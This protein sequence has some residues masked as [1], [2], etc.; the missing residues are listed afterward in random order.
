VPDPMWAEVGI[1]V[2][3]LRPGAVLDE[4]ELLAWLAPKVARYKLPRRVF[5]WDE[6]PRSG[7][8]KITKKLIRAELDA[9][10]CLPSENSSASAA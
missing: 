1:A 3:V 2:C 10:G 4:Q 9:R 8:G 6:L 5:F 7:Y